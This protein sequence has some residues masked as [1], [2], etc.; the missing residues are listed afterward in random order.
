MAAVTPHQMK[1]IKDAAAHHCGD[2]VTCILMWLETQNVNSKLLQE[3]RFGGLVDS[4]PLFLK[5][6]EVGT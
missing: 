5:Q 3:Q 6:L 1:G 4:K 2:P